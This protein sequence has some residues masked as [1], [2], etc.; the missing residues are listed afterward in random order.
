[1]AS[2][3]PAS[4]S[5]IRKTSSSRRIWTNSRLPR[6][7]MRASIKPAGRRRRVANSSGRSQQWCRLVESADLVFEQRQVMQRIEN[8]VLALVGASMPGDHLNPAGDHHL[9]DI[10]ADQHLAVAVGGRD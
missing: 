2:P 3:T 7:P 4:T 1:M 5:S 10:I 9:L 8:E 6:L